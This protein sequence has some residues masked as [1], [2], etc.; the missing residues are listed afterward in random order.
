MASMSKIAPSSRLRVTCVSTSVI[1]RSATLS[2]SINM[3]GD[4]FSSSRTGSADRTGMR[5]RPVL[6]AQQPQRFARPISGE[7]LRQILLAQVPA[8]QLTEHVAI[9]GGHGQV[10][11]FIELFFFETGP[12]AVD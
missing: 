7:N 9:V 8:D 4:P 11:T 5:L 2:R 6:S 12:P 10:A 1:F 3:T